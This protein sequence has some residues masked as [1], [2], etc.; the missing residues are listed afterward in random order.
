MKTLLQIVQE[1]CRDVGEPRPSVVASSPTETP[2]RMLALL[3]EAGQQLIKDHDWNVLKTIRTFTPVAAEAQTEPP[4]DYD[5]LTPNTTIW[6]IT[7]KR[8]LIGALSTDK[9]LQLYV[10]T[11]SSLDK[12]WTF[13]G[14]VFHI[15]PTPS[16]SDSFVYSYQSKNWVMNST[17]VAV[18]EF[19]ADDDTPRLPDELLK[20]E[21]IWRWKQKLGLDYAE[22]MANCGRLKETLISADRGTRIT[23]LSSPWSNRDLPDNYWPGVIT[24]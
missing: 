3:N 4:A 21:L 15:L 19:S 13:V 1:A 16:A 18:S 17:P 12:Y 5:R 2:L 7:N 9:W 20:L 24:G 11:I 14:G 8:P 22:E 6:D 23:S 10:N